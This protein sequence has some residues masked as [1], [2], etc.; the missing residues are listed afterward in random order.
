MKSR[1][2]SKTRSASEKKSA[3]SLEKIFLFTTVFLSILGLFFI[4][5][6]ST[7]E[8]YRLVGH[9]YHFLKQQS[10]ALFLGLIA[11]FVT[12]KWPFSFW[13]KTAGLWFIAGLTLLFLVLIPGF[14]IE[15]NGAKRWFVLGGRVFQPVE[16]FKFTL[17]LFSANWMSKN[18]KPQTFL[19]FTGLF[20][21]LLFFYFYLFYA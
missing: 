19:F 7:T 10:I 3:F 4:F 14:G 17:I 12:Q 21:L 5:E 20:S 2:R 18:P 8:S 6:A 9:Q 16:F 15:L 1:R 11:L 13:Q